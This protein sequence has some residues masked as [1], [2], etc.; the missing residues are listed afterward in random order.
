MAEDLQALMERIQKDAVEK[1]ELAAADIISKAKDKAAEIVKAAEDEA[2]AKLENADKEAQAFT[3]RSERTLE[4]SAR[5]LLLSVGK[6][7]DK[8]I[9]DLLSSSRLA[10]R[11]KATRASSL[12]SA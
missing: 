11:S 5:D 1:A 3:E 4:Q 2:K 12:A 8:K 9:L 10:S 6:N 7:L